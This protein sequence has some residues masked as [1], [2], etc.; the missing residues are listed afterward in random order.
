MLRTNPLTRGGNRIAVCTRG[1]GVIG[2]T[3][4]DR[5][6][7]AANK[8]GLAN[9]RRKIIDERQQ[10]IDQMK[11]NERNWGRQKKTGR[12]ANEYIICRGWIHLYHADGQL[13]A[14]YYFSKQKEKLEKISEALK[15]I[16]H[17]PGFYIEI[18]YNQKKY[19]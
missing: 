4:N 11:A 3:F 17:L 15:Q 13:G 5:L 2:R 19:Q 10:F 18:E 8:K 12:S 16:K 9:D 1:T 14:T 6:L 7:P